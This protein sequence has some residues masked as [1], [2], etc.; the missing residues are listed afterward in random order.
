MAEVAPLAHAHARKAAEETQ[1]VRWTTAVEEHQHA[2]SDFARAAKSTSDNEAFRILKQLEEQH[3]KLARIIRLQ[4]TPEV[5]I[6]EP[7][8]DPPAPVDSSP[9]KP[10]SPH[11]S[12][13]PATKQKSPTSAVAAAR[14]GSQARDSS[15]SLAREIASRRGIPQNGRTQP[16]AAAQARARQLSPES[17][18]TTPSSRAPKVPPSVVDSQ[19]SLAQA[20]QIKAAEDE[21]GFGKFYSSFKEGTMSKLSSALAFAGLPLTADD[22]RPDRKQTVTARND[23]DVRKYISEAALR[24]IEED[25]RQRGKLGHGFGPAESFYV[26]PPTGMMTSFADIARRRNLEDDE[27][28]FVDAREGP[29]PASPRQSTPGSQA[30][31]VRTSF[32]KARTQEELEL[33]NGTLKVTLEQLASRLANFEA[34]AQDASMMALTQSM[35]SLRAPARAPSPAPAPAPKTIPAAGGD[36]HGAPEHRLRQLEEQVARDAEEKRKLQTQAER[37]AKELKKWDARYE[38]LMQSALAKQQAKDLA[39]KVDQVAKG[40]NEPDAAAD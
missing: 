21:D 3:Q 40:K 19:T 32:G 31:G 6:L 33:E 11:A 16:S 1:H 23:H 37:Q 36:T 39:K 25:H 35:V 34:H 2:A 30:G 8:V 38:R 24:A 17:L 20:K 13:K 26:V 9:S 7:T 22:I 5:Q 15:P 28:D 10:V 27:D 29:G 4:D 12:M 18:R 14:I